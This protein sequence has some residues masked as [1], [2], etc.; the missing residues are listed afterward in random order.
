MI[1]YQTLLISTDNQI[2]TI[3]LN[4]P[5]VRNAFNDVLISELT[6]AITQASQNDSIRLIVLKG[7]GKAFCAGGDLNWMKASVAASH[8]DNLR[9]ASHLSHMLQALYK[10]PKPVI[11]C[12][13]GSVM[14]GGTGVVAACDYVIADQETLFAFSEV[15][16]GLIP[17]VI[18]PFVMEKIGPSHTRALFLTGQRFDAQQALQIGLIHEISNHENDREAKLTRLVTDLLSGG[19]LAQAHVKKYLAEIKNL[20]FSKQHDYAVE[21][22]A[23]LRVTAEAQ[24]GMDAFL[25]RGKAPWIK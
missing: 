5:D 22:L 15:K 20:S 11:A 13:H 23:V 1:N 4:R 7:S 10:A 6:K 17:A 16:L 21:T 3:T 12:V 18:G 25:N 9:D 2:A 19:P 24:Q 8:D 14:G